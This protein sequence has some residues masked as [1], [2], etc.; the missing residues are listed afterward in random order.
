MS[1]N[2]I[3]DKTLLNAITE[4]IVATVQPRRGAGRCPP[5]QYSQGNLPQIIRHVMR[6]V[7]D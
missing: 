6:D 4:R 7:I 2:R 1:E 5:A 3:P